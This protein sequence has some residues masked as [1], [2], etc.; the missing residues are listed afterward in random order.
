M[1]TF[2]RD[3]IR[4]HKEGLPVLTNLVAGHVVKFA[5]LDIPHT[6]VTA[7][8]DKVRITGTP[9]PGFGIQWLLSDQLGTPRLVFDE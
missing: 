2:L 1:I 5:G 8:F 4:L 9:K 7:F 6:G 3:L